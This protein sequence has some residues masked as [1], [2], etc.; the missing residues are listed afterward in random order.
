M[1]THKQEYNF[2]AM[3]HKCLP[4]CKRISSVLNL[5]F[6]GS[7]DVSVWDKTLLLFRTL[8]ILL[9]IIKVKFGEKQKQQNKNKNKKQ[10]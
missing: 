6:E 9:D 4:Q 2:S 1:L 8:K 5:L 3:V 10:W 7:G